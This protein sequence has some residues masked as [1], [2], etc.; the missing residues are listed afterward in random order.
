MA[1]NPEE[2]FREFVVRGEGYA[3][4]L[5][6]SLVPNDMQ[7]HRQY[8][9][10]LDQSEEIG[11]IYEKYCREKKA[12]KEGKTRY[13][14]I[15]FL[16]SNV[17]PLGV[18][19]QRWMEELS[20]GKPLDELL[21][22]GIALTSWTSS[23]ESIT[24]LLDL[25]ALHKPPFG[26]ATWYIKVNVLYTELNALSHDSRHKYG[27]WSYDALRFEKRAKK[28]TTQL[29]IFIQKTI[30]KSTSTRS[31]TISSEK[32]YRTAR[33][34]WLYIIQLAQWQFEAGLLD[35]NVYFDGW[36]ELLS[37]MRE[38]AFPLEMEDCFVILSTIMHHLSPLFRSGTHVRSLVKS[39]LTNVAQFCPDR[40]D[41]VP[42][43]HRYTKPSFLPP[44]SFASPRHEH[45]FQ[46]LCELL[47]STLINA[48]DAL[49]RV[50]AGT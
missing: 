27:D 46:T 34:Q 23:K 47:R 22:G 2:Q 9:S 5:H 16:K 17:R 1:S 10:L 7:K 26:R 31:N 13:G 28:W 45:L 32:E 33:E 6:R 3:Q 43:S 20:C 15:S 44:T 40:K 39:L 14:L 21:Q 42:R 36:M 18:K 19:Q 50:D 49:V 29:M 38:G 30:R 37:S 4:A 8:G 11:L 25:L 24:P 35:T 48:P 12:S 41:K